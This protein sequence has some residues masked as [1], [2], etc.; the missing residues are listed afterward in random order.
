MSKKNIFSQWILYCQY[1]HRLTGKQLADKVGV[2]T[3]TLFSWRTGA[4]KP[5]VRYLARMVELTDGQITKED[6]RPDLFK[7]PTKAS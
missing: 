3:Q 5:P 1:R 6:L 4:S 7:A 2:T